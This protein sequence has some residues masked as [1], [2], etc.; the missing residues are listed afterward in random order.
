MEITAT[1]DG[2]V[3]T[4]T[5]ASIR[6]HL[7][8]EDSDGISTLPNTKIFE[9]LALMG[10]VS[11]SD[12]LTFRKG[13]FFPQWRFL[14]H[15]ILHCLSAKK[16]AWDQ[17][18][19][20]IATVIICLATNRTFNFSKLI[21]DGMVKNLDNQSKILIYP[22]F[23]Q[24]FLNKHQ[25]Q[26][27]PH[28]RT[29]IAPTLTQKLFGNM[30]RIS[31]SYNGV[32]ISLLPTMLV[33]GPIFQSE[34]ST[35]PVESHHTPTV[36][37]STSPPH[38]SPTLRSPIGQETKVPQLSS[39]PYTSVA[40]EAASTSVDVRHG[41]AATTVTSLDAGQGSGNINK[42]PSM[43]HD[44]SLRR[45]HTLRS[46]KGRM[47]QNELMDLVTK[48]S[49]KCAALE[50]NLRQTKKVYGDAFTRL[51]KK[52]RSMIKEIDQDTGITLVQ[53]NDEDQVT[54]TKVSAQGKAHTQQD[55]P[56]D[57]LRVLS[58]AKYASYGSRKLYPI[59]VATKDKGK[60]IMQE[61]EFP[62]KMKQR[63][64]IQIIKDE[65]VA[66][67]LH[68]EFDAVER[69]RITRAHEEASCFNIEEWEDIKATIKELINQRK[70]YFAQQ[71]AEE[72]R[73]KP[74]T[75]AQQRT[76]MSNYI[77]HMGSHTLQ[78]LKKLSF[79]ELKA[80]FETTMRRVQTFH[81]IESEG[82]KTVLELTTRSLK[83]DAEVELDHEGSKKQ[84]TNEASGSV[85]E[86]PEEE[87]TELSQEDL[88]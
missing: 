64:Q 48:L 63:E 8:L 5:K 25:R 75:Q 43:P 32:D 11:N 4:V 34:G 72:R 15:T 65:E 18:S 9:Q 84:K 67:K 28:K 76:Y 78:Q 40:D 87:E 59:K 53:V 81:P 56:E 50:I 58:A 37:L 54:P 39:P 70:R 17:F 30:R 33:Q 77:K 21:F 36:A 57:H 42:T 38:I 44:S 83:R 16:I 2:R 3:K 61:S 22:R 60:A 7:K 27:L 46:D 13:H 35:V 12:R 73:N 79:D 19:S 74:L 20:N 55:Q 88:Q 1:I 62:K 14:I 23:I 49:D 26:L 71:R 82:E 47:Q 86:Q 6:R 10:Y 85:Q 68:E 66:L 52:G 31:K 29:Y 80:L 41:G 69:Q 45:G 51:I 24:I